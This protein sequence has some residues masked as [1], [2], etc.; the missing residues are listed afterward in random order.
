M[1]RKQLVLKEISEMPESESLLEDIWHMIQNKRRLAT[2]DK[3]KSQKKFKG[4]PLLKPEDLKKMD[5]D[6]PVEPEWEEMW[7]QDHQQ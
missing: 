7:K 4:R 1:T 3:K 2:Q 6:L 5:N